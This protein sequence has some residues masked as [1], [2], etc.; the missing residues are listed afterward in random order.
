[1]NNNILE[2][3]NVFYKYDKKGHSVNNL[4]FSIKKGSFHAF[5]GE[6]GAGKSTTIKLIVGLIN[7]YEG[8]ILINNN[9]VKETFSRGCISFIPDKAIFSSSMSLKQYLLSSIMLKRN[10]KNNV[11]QEIDKWCEKLDLTNLINK[12]PNKFSAGQK[13]KVFLIRAI[14]ERA[15]LIILDEPA[16]N[17]DPTTRK[18]LFSILKNITKTGTSIFISSH[19][20]DEIKNY[21]TNAT[22]IK[23][24]SI[25]WSGEVHGDMINDIYNKFYLE[26][27]YE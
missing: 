25:V 17:L 15:E 5:V 16:A 9:D 10:D 6:N 20:L 18:Q 22:F 24:G 3:K 12:N 13:K 23:K 11:L 26:E 7:N 21:A 14:L 4:T 27:Y 8:E 2:L 19:I 1:M